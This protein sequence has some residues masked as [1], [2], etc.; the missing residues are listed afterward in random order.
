MKKHQ[1]L[2]LLL[3]F[4]SCSGDTASD[5]LNIPTIDFDLAEAQG[6]VLTSNATQTSALQ[7]EM[8]LEELTEEEAISNLKKMLSDGSLAPIIYI[9]SESGEEITS[10][11]DIEDIM[12]SSFGDVIVNFTGYGVILNGYYC[13][14]V[15][16]NFEEEVT[17]CIHPLEEYD[18]GGIEQIIFNS[19]GDVYYIFEHK[20]Y[21]MD[22]TD[23]STVFVWEPELINFGI[24]S[25]VVGPDNSLILSGS[26]A[27]LNDYFFRYYP[28]SENLET[29]EVTDE[30]GL[31]LTGL[32]IDLLTLENSLLYITNVDN[33]WRGTFSEDEILTFEYLG[34]FEID[35]FVTTSEGNIYVYGGSTTATLISSSP[36]EEITFS[37][38]V[39]EELAEANGDYLF[40]T[41]TDSE[42]NRVFMRKSLLGDREEIDLLGGS[43]FLVQ[44]FDVASNGDVYFGA[45]D[46]DTL[47]VYLYKYNN[48]TGEL[49]QMDSLSGDLEEILVL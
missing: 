24:N 35:N 40:L 43:N 1:F 29:I 17:A 3:I 39:D 42:G 6:L 26:L 48:T 44:N 37:T 20:L 11:I 19:E 15:L 14:D 18:D 4:Y 25:Y 13:K 47:T 27:G 10:T 41:G 22:R 30:E 9:D 16:L 7:K 45:L 34:E 5:D 21:K 36:F 49:E 23:Y 2:V 32:E 12:F 31:V 38:V 28:D 46:L 33:V 8:S